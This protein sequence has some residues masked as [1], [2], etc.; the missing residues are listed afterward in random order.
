MIGIIVA[1]VVVTV[2]GGSGPGQRISDLGRTHIAEGTSISQTNVRQYNSDPPTSGPHWP[3]PAPQGV[4][5]TTV[6]DERLVHSLEH[7]YVVIHHNCNPA[8]PECDP[9]LKSLEGVFNR[10]NS[11]VIVN[12][13]PQTKSRIALTAWTR[14]DTM[15][16]FDE[17]R[18]V[19]FIDAYRGKIGPEPDA[20]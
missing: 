9:L 16:E 14:L 19:K 1:V 20:P 18:I 10:Y 12:Y 15:D 17:Q 7:G 6:P 4:Y 8:Q 5:S 13:R 3:S 11:K 2:G